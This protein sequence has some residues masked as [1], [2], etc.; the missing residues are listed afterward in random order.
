[1][2]D[3]NTPKYLAQYVPVPMNGVPVPL[4]PPDGYPFCAGWLPA[5]TSHPGSTCTPV[6]LHPGI[7]VLWERD[8]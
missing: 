2:S 5:V 3:S 6:A 4:M 8:R 7:L 1:M